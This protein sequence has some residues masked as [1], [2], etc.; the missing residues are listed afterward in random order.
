MEPNESRTRVYRIE[1][2]AF[3][4]W[5]WLAIGA[6]LIVIAAFGFSMA[7]LRQVGQFQLQAMCTIPSVMAVA[8]FAKAWIARSQPREIEVSPS[9]LKVTRGS[10][11]DSI[12]WDQ[13]VWAAVDKTS[14]SQQPRL[15]VYD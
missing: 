10:R 6:G 11:E 3:Q 4:A 14:L 15:N 12:D 2:S 5:M 9:G 8:A 7:V 13:I 1:D